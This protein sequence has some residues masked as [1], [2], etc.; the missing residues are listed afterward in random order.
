VRHHGRDTPAGFDQR[1]KG[2]TEAER[3]EEE[4][5]SQIP[6]FIRLWPPMGIRKSNPSNLPLSQ[7]EG[8]VFLQECAKRY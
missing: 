3:F 2:G 8:I 6:W 1:F 4:A 7:A 5:E